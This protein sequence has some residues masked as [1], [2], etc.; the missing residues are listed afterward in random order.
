LPA[1]QIRVE[2]FCNA[3]AAEV[4]V[5]TQDFRSFCKSD[6]SD[7]AYVESIARRYKVSRETI[8]RRAMDRGLVSQRDYR[9]KAQEWAAQAEVS[10]AGRSRRGDYYANTVSYLG[11]G[12]VKLAFSRY[13][14]GRCTAQQLADCLNVKVR[15]LPGL[16]PF[17]VGAGGAP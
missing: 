6:F 7:D 16:E 10:L 8:L 4:L 9:A 11:E 12:F 3:F 17:A 14:K 5:P 13:Y 15:S 1:E 2:V